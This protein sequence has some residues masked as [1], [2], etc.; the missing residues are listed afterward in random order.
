MAIDALGA[1]LRTYTPAAGATAAPGGDKLDRD[2]FLQLLTTQLRYQNPLEPISSNNFVGEL[3][4]FSTMESMD[5]LNKGLREMLLAQQ[6]SQGAALIGKTV[7]YASGSAGTQQGVVGGVGIQDGQIQLQVGDESVAMNQV[8]GIDLKGKRKAWEF[9]PARK[10]QAFYA[11]A[12]VTDELIVTGSRDK[13]V[14]ALDRGT[15]RLAWHYPAEVPAAGA[16]GFPGSPALG[17][18]LVFVTGLDGRVFAF[19]P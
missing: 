2:G 19:N 16:Y 13:K 8:F 12:A 9:E 7:R 11:S 4:N 6:I 17:A 3:A 14:Y 18:G 15:G 5:N 1:G 10:A